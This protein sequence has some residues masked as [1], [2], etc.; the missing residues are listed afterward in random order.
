[1]IELRWLKCWNLEK[2]SFTKTLQYRQQADGVWQDW[3]HI[4][5][6]WNIE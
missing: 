5:E 2:T 3:Q 6:E 4:K 1:M